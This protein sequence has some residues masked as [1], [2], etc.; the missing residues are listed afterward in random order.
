[1]EKTPSPD[2]TSLTFCPFLKAASASLT[3]VCVFS[4]LY[5]VVDRNITISFCT[6]SSFLLFELKTL[7]PCHFPSLM[8]AGHSFA[9]RQEIFQCRSTLLQHLFL[10]K[11]PSLHRLPLAQNCHI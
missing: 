6:A 3:I 10:S 7:R 1:M 4:K 2:A 5:G 8:C 11:T 9:G